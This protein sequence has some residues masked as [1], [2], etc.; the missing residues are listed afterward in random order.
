MSS[1]QRW[2]LNV[3]DL[4]TSIYLGIYAR[5]KAKPQRLIVNATVD[6][7]Y[8]L[9]PKSIDEC[10]NYDHIYDLVTKT[11]PTRSHID[12]LETLALE[13]LEYIFRSDI[14]EY[15]KVKLDK[16][17]VFSEAKAVGV[18]IEWTREDFKRRLG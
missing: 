18:E 16:P 7:V 9:K 8:S 14:V 13:L 5:E 12:L 10:F 15:A 11:W 2:R 1:D 4:E 6:A 3:T 17:D